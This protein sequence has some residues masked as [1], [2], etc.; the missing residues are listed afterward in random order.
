MCAASAAFV[1]GQGGVISVSSDPAGTSCNLTDKTAGICTYYVIHTETSGAGGVVFSAPIPTCFAVT[2]ISDE[3]VFPVTL[4]D[5][6][7]GV[8]VAYGSCRSGPVHILTVKFFCQ[9]LTG[10]CCAYWVLPDPRVESG[11]IEVSDCGLNLLYATGGK[12]VVNGT[13]EC[14]CQQASEASSWGRVKSLY[15][16]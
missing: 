7:S 6:Q 8:T 11:K 14:P 3:P 13:T 15:E 9:G 10:A 1:Y 16:D 12:A 2:W 4:G 5:S